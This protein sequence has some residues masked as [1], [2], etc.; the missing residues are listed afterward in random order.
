MLA[1]ATGSTAASGAAGPVDAH[2]SVSTS[3]PA[4]HTVAGWLAAGLK[5]RVASRGVLSQL[6][7]NDDAWI[8]DSSCLKTAIDSTN[9]RSYVIGDTSSATV[10]LYGDSSA[11]EWVTV[12]PCVGRSVGVTT[13]PP[14]SC[15]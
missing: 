2:T 4:L 6:S 13:V 5:L 11:D 15:R 9:A 3:L 10:V 7:G 8:P 14:G 1:V 12:P